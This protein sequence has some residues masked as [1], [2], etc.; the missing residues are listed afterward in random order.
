[1][2][3]VKETKPKSIREQA[4]ENVQ[5]SQELFDLIGD[6]Q[7]GKVTRE[8]FWRIHDELV[9]AEIVAL[10]QAPGSDVDPEFYEG[11]ENCA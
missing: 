1:M 7:R 2:P 10:S 8:Q 11:V 9:E 4:L 3:D 5:E 6:A